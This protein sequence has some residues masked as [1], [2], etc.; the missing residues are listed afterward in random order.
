[1]QWK[2]NKLAGGQHKKA[3][4]TEMLQLRLYTDWTDSPRTG[5]VKHFANTYILYTVNTANV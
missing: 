4:V 2:E 3:Q 1:M 5:Y